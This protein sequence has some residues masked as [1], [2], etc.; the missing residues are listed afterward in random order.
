MK[1]FIALGVALVVMLFSF[2][3]ATTVAEVNNG[4]SVCEDIKPNANPHP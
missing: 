3:P 1:K 2:L 4:V